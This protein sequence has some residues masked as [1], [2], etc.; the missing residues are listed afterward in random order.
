MAMARASRITTSM[1]PTTAGRS[2]L[3]DEHHRDLG[4]LHRPGGSHLQLHQHRDQQRRH[5]ATRS[6][7]GPG[8]DNDQAADPNADP[9]AYAHTD[10]HANADTDSNAATSR[11]GSVGASRNDQDSGNGKKAKKETVIVVDF[12]AA[13]NAASADNAG[14]YELAP[15]IKVKASGKGKNRKPATTKLGTPVPV[16]SAV[17]TASN[18]QVTLTPRAKLAASKPEELIVNGSLIL[19]TLGREID[20]AGDGQA[21]SDYIATITGTRVT[22]GGLPSARMGPRSDGV[23]EVVDLL[24]AHGELI[25]AHHPTRTPSAASLAMQLLDIQLRR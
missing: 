14:A 19:D 4:D 2:S 24:L 23:T 17:Y 3:Q 12:S 6:K 25:R 13:L 18:N 20:G 5:Q 21:G 16:A 11:D 15:I 8:H 9:H 10:S 7:H 22:T 1:S